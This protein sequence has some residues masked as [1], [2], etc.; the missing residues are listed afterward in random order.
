MRDQDH[1]KR[2]RHA[3]I[4]RCGRLIADPETHARAGAKIKTDPADE[5]GQAKHQQQAKGAAALRLA[6]IEAW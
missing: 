4:A 2:R 1:E 6:S 5:S 3:H